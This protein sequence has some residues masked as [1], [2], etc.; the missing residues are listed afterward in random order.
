MILFMMHFFCSSEMQEIHRQFSMLIAHTTTNNSRPSSPVL[1]FTSD[2]VVMPPSIEIMQILLDDWNKAQHQKLVDI[3]GALTA[4][5]VDTIRQ[6][7]SD[8]YDYT[9]ITCRLAQYAIKSVRYVRLY[10]IKYSV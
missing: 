3:T 2:P 8:R 10:K 9:R 5:E 1:D 7:N 4:N 6:N